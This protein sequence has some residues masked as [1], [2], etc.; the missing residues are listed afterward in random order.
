MLARLWEERG[1]QGG[2]VLRSATGLPLNPDTVTKRFKEYL[3][4]ADLPEH[5]SFHSL[6]HTCATWLAASGTPSRIIQ[7]IMGHGQLSTTEIYMHAASD[8]LHSAMDQTFN[9]RSSTG[10]ADSGE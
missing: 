3:R 6:R 4:K 2:P 5:I 10:E 7:E 9:R 1:E 8:R